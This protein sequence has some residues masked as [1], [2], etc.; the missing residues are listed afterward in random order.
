[1]CLSIC[2]LEK[3]VATSNNHLDVKLRQASERMF[4]VIHSVQQTQP[5]T[6][7][8]ISHSLLDLKTSSLSTPFSCTHMHAHTHTHIHQWCEW[9]ILFCESVER[10][11]IMIAPSSP[12]LPR[13]SISTC[14]D[15]CLRQSMEE[16][17]QMWPP[18]P[19]TWCTLEFLF[20][21]I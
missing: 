4:Y 2:Q 8:S 20:S 1:M 12:T 16:W 15:K 3:H 10:R 9:S 17:R 7:F 14:K 5:F 18:P 19:S 13:A 21:H 6:L 11:W